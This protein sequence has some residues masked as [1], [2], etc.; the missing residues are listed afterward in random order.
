MPSVSG[1]RFQATVYVNAGSDG[2]ENFRALFAESVERR[3]YDFPPLSIVVKETSYKD[4]EE[5]SLDISVYRT[6][7]A[8][9][10]VQLVHILSDIQKDMKLPFNIKLETWETQVESVL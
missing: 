8:V 2:L 4:L 3:G 6:G 1:V 5:I 10:K 7:A 9:F